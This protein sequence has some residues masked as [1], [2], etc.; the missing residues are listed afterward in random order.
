MGK[1][2]SGGECAEVI[3]TSTATPFLEPVNSCQGNADSTACHRGCTLGMCQGQI[4][5]TGM[6]PA[7]M[8]NSPFN[9]CKAGGECVPTEAPTEAPVTAPRST[10]A[11]TRLASATHFDVT[12]TW[13]AT[14]VVTNLPAQKQK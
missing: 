6:M 12:D 5:L 2:E 14:M 9:I 1:C 10:F 8:P 4:C 3:V 7:C 11:G 13:I